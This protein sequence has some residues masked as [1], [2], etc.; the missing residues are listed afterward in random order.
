MLAMLS[1]FGGDL[2]STVI[3]LVLFIVFMVFG[4]RIMVT[5]AVLKLETEVYQLEEIAV[6]SRRDVISFISKRPNQRL[7]ESVRNFMNF[8]AISPVST[9][10]YGI[11]KKLDHI[12]RHSEKRIDYF[13]NEIAPELSSDKKQDVKNALAGA[14]TCHNIA[15]IVRH[16][17]E[18]IKKYKL[19]QLAMV[20][21]MQMPLIIR[22]SKAA[23]KATNAFLDG[24]PIG[25]GIGP[26]V[27]ASLIKGKPTRYEE[28]EF[29]VYKTKIEGKD[30][31]VSKADGPGA[32]TGYPGNLITKLMKKNKIH[33]IITIDAA[34]KLE[35]EKTASIA[36]GVG[37]AMGGNGVDRYEIEEIIVKRNI[38]LDAIAIKV[39]DEEALGPMK[40]EIFDSVPKVQEIL[41]ERIKKA[42]KGEK[43]LVMGV[44]NTCGI[45]NDY[46]AIPNAK[47]RLKKHLKKMG[48]EKKSRF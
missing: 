29:V 8:F 10:P 13:V 21:Q 15:K 24:V 4:P 42:K 34:M 47:E 2:L 18:L 35:G 7:K 41:R 31:L 9:D 14:I 36:E 44:G 43:I 19:F 39:S 6:K 12:S 1:Q 46:K 23:S 20:I 32:T 16:Y 5:Q 27:T 3:W 11:M 17:L 48:P 38:P 37:V 26:L 33:R 30:V 45:G 25:D 28:E 40:K 22:I